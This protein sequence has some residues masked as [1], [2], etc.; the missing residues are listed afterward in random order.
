LAYRAD[1]VNTVIDAKGDLL[2]GTAADTIDRIAVGANDTV[3]T[4]DSSTATGL[5]WATSAAG[6]MTLIST[7]TLTGT[8]VTLSSIP[9]TYNSLYLVFKNVDPVNDTAYVCLRLNGTSSV[10]YY[11]FN[12]FG[13]SSSSAADTRWIVTNGID[14]S[15]NAN[16][17]TV[18]I[19]DYTNSTTRKMAFTNYVGSP[20]SGSADI[21][22][23]ITFGGSKIT[24]AVS[25]L[26]IT[27]NSGDFSSGT[28]LLYGVK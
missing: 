18:I 8:T 27:T 6:G 1:T 22:A 12:T 25:S 7:T 28:V 16:L 3:L 21:S 26:T 5:K 11:N 10:D 14:V 17:S 24:A 4:A 23:L 20:D 9:Q 19:P 13:A 2:A 15:V